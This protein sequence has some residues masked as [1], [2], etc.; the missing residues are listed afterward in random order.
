MLGQQGNNLK[1]IKKALTLKANAQPGL[2]ST[3]SQVYEDH[4][5]P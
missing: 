1:G 5:M 4:K 2:E 3:S